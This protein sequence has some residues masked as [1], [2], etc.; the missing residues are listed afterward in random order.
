VAAVGGS[1]SGFFALERRVQNDKQEEQTTT[2]AKYLDSGFARM[3]S[4]TNK[5]EIQGSFATLRMTATGDDGVGGTR[6]S[7]LYLGGG[8]DF[9]YRDVWMPDECP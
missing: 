8:E 2:R 4:K 6:G 7:T 5:D 1:S 3:T 9:L